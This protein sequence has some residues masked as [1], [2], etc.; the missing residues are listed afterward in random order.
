MFTSS[1]RIVS[2]H[3]V[4]VAMWADSLLGSTW[5]APITARALILACWVAHQL[6]K[7]EAVPFGLVGQVGD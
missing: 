7:V 6:P 4:M 3:V 2:T 1:V 5:S